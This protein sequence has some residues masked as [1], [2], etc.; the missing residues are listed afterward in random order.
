MAN[1]SGMLWSATPVAINM[2]VLN[3][4]LSIIPFSR[5]ENCIWGSRESKMSISNAPNTKPIIANMQLISIDSC[6]SPV[7]AKV[8]IIPEAKPM[9]ADIKTLVGLNMK[10]INA[11]KPVHRPAI[12]ASK[13]GYIQ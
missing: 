5:I 10:I 4:F 8:S 11:P 13:M 3:L 2:A 6:S 1:P 9:L 7:N 12:K